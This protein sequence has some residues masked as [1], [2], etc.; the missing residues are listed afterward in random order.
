MKRSVFSSFVAL[1][2]SFILILGVISCSDSH[3]RRDR[4]DSDESFSDEL[5]SDEW[6]SY[7]ERQ[8]SES[9]SEYESWGESEYESEV[10]SEYE[11]EVESEPST[12]VIPDGMI[13]AKP[14]SVA[15]LGEGFNAMYLPDTTKIQAR[16]GK[17][18]VCLD[19][20]GKM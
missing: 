13:T 6:E 17:I 18:D 4:D 12:D 9:E 8:E 2:L 14:L 19:F 10:E 20:E 5:S 15:E 1:F 7:F 3:S 11:S 16:T